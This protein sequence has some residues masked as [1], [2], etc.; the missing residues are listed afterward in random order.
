MRD[1]ARVQPCR[2][3][4]A[5]WRFSD[6]STF[7]LQS[8]RATLH[9]ALKGLTMVFWKA[10]T[11]RTLDSFTNTRRLSS[12][13]EGS[14]WPSGAT[15]PLSSLVTSQ[16][17]VPADPAGPNPD[18]QY[19]KRRSRGDAVQRK[20]AS[21]ASKALG[22]V[23]VTCLVIVG[24]RIIKSG[25]LDA[26]H[27]Q[28]PGISIE[29]LMEHSILDLIANPPQTA[30]SPAPC[31]ARCPYLPKAASSICASLTPAFCNCSRTI[32]VFASI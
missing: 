23:K 14:A 12:W 2:K 6:E 11:R 19:H 8:W 1:V 29:L 16:E 21:F 10:V 3:A 5:R 15:N 9:G 24:Q 30:T 26:F 7:C 28:N 32:S 17:R 4:R 25:L 13:C 20:V 31:H 27:S 22:P 18:F